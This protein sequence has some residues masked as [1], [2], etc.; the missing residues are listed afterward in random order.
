MKHVRVMN[1]HPMKSIETQLQIM[2]VH[3]TCQYGECKWISICDQRTHSVH[4]IRWMGFAMPINVINNF[5]DT[6]KDHQWRYIFFFK[7]VDIYRLL[8]EQ[9]LIFLNAIQL[10]ASKIWTLNDNRQIDQPQTIEIF[11]NLN[12]RC[13]LKIKNFKQIKT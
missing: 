3:C 5:V 7:Y 6:M 1:Q 8:N 10:L 9:K 11:Y 13:L 2:Y 4:F 12:L